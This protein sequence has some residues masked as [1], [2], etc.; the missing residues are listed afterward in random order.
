MG[1]CKVWRRQARGFVPEGLKTKALLWGAAWRPCRTCSPSWRRSSGTFI[2]ASGIHVAYFRAT[3]KVFFAGSVF[4]G[5]IVW[6]TCSLFP[7]LSRGI[8]AVGRTAKTS[9]QAGRYGSICLPWPW[10]SHT[11]AILFQT[12]LHRVAAICPPKSAKPQYLPLHFSAALWARNDCRARVLVGN[13][14]RVAESK[15]SSLMARFTVTDRAVTAPL[16]RDRR[17]VAHWVSGC[18]QCPV[19]SL[20]WGAKDVDLTWL[21]DQS[22]MAQRASVSSEARITRAPIFQA[23]L[24]RVRCQMSGKG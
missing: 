6:T 21:C 15:V 12:Q 23:Q 7:L 24:Q 9:V 16:C 19:A 2:G 5:L 11:S 4:R 20:T 3:V 18:R 13:P 14:C 1:V 8:A 22:Q 10:P 17:L